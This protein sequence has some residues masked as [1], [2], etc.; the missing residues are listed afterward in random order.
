MQVGFEKSQWR[1]WNGVPLVWYAVRSLPTFPGSP[2]RPPGG[3]RF[4]PCASGM[5]CAP[6]APRTRGTSPMAAPGPREP[7]L[8]RLLA[9]LEIA[10]Q[11]ESANQGG[12]VPGIAALGG[13]G[14]E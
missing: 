6:P 13:T 4:K 11:F 12:M 3:E 14:V 1:E 8:C 2:P 5:A 7:T 9:D 10:H